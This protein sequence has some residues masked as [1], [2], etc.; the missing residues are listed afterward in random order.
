MSQTELSVADP[1]AVFL[2]AR[3]IVSNYIDNDF[4]GLIT[5]GPPGNGKTRHTIILLA[6][7][8]GEWEDARDKNGNKISMVFEDGMNWDAW[9]EWMKHSLED[10][11]GMI[12]H[13]HNKGRQVLMGALDDA[14]IAASNLRWQEQMG[15][16]L[17][18]YANVQRRDFA[19]LDFTTPSPLW[20]LGHVRNMP[21]GH[22]ARVN[23]TTGNKYQRHRRYARIY[24]GWMSPD[25]KKSGVRA[26]WDDWF[27]TKIPERV[28]REFEP[29]NR[30]YAEVAIQT[31]RELYYKMK[32]KGQDKKAEEY[33]RE[34][35]EK[36]GIKIKTD[37]EIAKGKL[38]EAM[39]S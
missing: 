22:T 12:D 6:Q 37:E 23:K 9:K 2:T 17:S 3:H 38:D 33:R 26:L 27:S 36:A 18:D 29:V 5:Y 4:F 13:A 25:F 21:G 39:P 34:L 31:A 1:M 20:L 14:G 16:A 32:G 11:L 10:F 28:E 8:Y 7:V 35:A 30:H 24:E 15:K 19:C